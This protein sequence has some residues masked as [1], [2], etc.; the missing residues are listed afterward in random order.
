MSAS[1]PLP[2]S[3]DPLPGESLPG[4]VLRLA[5][6]LEIT[7]QHVLRLTSLTV[8]ARQ[9]AVP[10]YQAVHLPKAAAAAFGRATRLSPA[11]VSGL[12]LSPFAYRYRPYQQH[13]G[14]VDLSERAHWAAPAGWASHRLRRYCPQCLA[15]DGTTVQQR[16]GGAWRRLWHLP[17]SFACL[18]HQRM[19]ETTCP[20]CEKPVNQNLGSH[21]IARPA[22]GLLHPAQCRNPAAD[23]GHPAWQ[24]ACAGRLDTPVPPTTVPADQLDCQ[25]HLH[26][27][28]TEPDPDARSIGQHV[29]ALTCFDDLY[30]A[31][32]LLRP[33]P[34]AGADPAPRERRMRGDCR[35]PQDPGDAAKV[36]TTAHQLLA[37]DAAQAETMIRELLTAAR[38]SPH[39]WQA[40]LNSNHNS[41]PTLSRL[42]READSLPRPQPKPRKPQPP[43]P[44]S[45]HGAFTWHH[46]PQYLPEEWLHYFD[47]P[48][49]AHEALRRAVPVHLVKMIAGGSVQ[50]CAERLG[51]P[52]GT[53]AWAMGNARR[54]LADADALDALEAGLQKLADHLDAQTCLVDYHRRRQALDTWSLSEADWRRLSENL[55][56]RTGR[57]FD[58]AVRRDTAAVL[59]WTDITQ[60]HSHQAYVVHRARAAAL[61]ARSPLL[62]SLT[63]TRYQRRCGRA[64]ELRPIA[65]QLDAYARDLATAID[66]PCN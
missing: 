62:Q 26:A 40:V 14:R 7:P 18:A 34:A 13:L 27:L 55:P 28:L 22:L 47:A 2:R 44:P 56:E 42:I 57:R 36:L 58:D 24:E 11:E 38:W 15:S 59:I 64:W 53:A 17:V 19:L 30:T 51:V 61:P 16:H 32:V 25:R 5:H 8:G 46:I 29:K 10:G 35:L 33:V 4:F 41:S 37:A 60:S 21:L 39:R 63:E 23:T 31:T 6:R 3:L 9:I 65:E 12:C 1:R 43:I 49:G 52:F 50:D 54:R 45:H 48:A 66:R 20:H